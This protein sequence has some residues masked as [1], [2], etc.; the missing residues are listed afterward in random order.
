MALR[1]QS[2]VEAILSAGMEVNQKAGHGAGCKVDDQYL[3]Y[4]L[5]AKLMAMTAIDLLSDNAAGA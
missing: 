2:C 4:I 1:T 3:A 5:P